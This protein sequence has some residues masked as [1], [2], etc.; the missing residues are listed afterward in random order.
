M[1]QAVGSGK[2]V[3]DSHAGSA[4]IKSQAEVNEMMKSMKEEAERAKQE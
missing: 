1:G 4:T 2:G 3:M